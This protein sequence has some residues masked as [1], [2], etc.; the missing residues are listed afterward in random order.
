ITVNPGILDVQVTA[1]PST[2]ISKQQ[3]EISIYVTCNAKPVTGA[4]VTISSDSGSLSSTTGV[5]DS[6]GRCTF[7]F[8]APE[9]AADLSI[10]VEVNAAKNGYVSA[11][12]QI[13]ITVIPETGGWSITT[14]LLIT[15][16]IV[17]AVVVIVLVKLKIISFSAEEND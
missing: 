12:S 15:I 17:L 16:P 14:I 10:V 7:I 13:T 9:T 5:T 1:N 3:T 11:E 4:S 6:N 2:I 8:N